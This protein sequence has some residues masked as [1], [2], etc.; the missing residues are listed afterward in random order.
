MTA[1]S[2]RPTRRPREMDRSSSR[3]HLQVF[4]LQLDAR[5]AI[6]LIDRRFAGQVDERADAQLRLE[7]PEAEA[8]ALD[9][10]LLLAELKLEVIAGLADALGGL[11]DLHAAQ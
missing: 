1:G 6:P 5:P 4:Q 11:H 9:H 10:P 2:A 8:D 3:S 7:L